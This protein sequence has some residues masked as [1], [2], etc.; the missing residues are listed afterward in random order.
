MCL[1]RVLSSLNTHVQLDLIF[2]TELTELPIFYIFETST[3]FSECLI[4]PSKEIPDILSA[5][6]RRWIS[7]YDSPKSLSGDVEFSGSTK[8]IDS[9]KHH[10][11]KFET[12]PSRRHNKSG[13]VET[14]K[15]LLRKLVHRLISDESAS[16]TTLTVPCY[17]ILFLIA[18]S[19]HTSPPSIYFSDILARDFFF[20][21]IFS[22]AGS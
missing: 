17:N 1:S 5:L 3:E 22:M 15:P 6:D 2:I 16:S 14:K 7:I 19:S 9:L 21:L 12:L 20:Y 8:F 18:S 11:I 10:F 4:L 13:S